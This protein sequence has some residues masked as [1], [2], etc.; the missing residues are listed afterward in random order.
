[1]ASRSSSIWARRRVPISRSRCRRDRRRHVRLWRRQ[2]ARRLRRVRAVRL[3]RRHRERAAPRD[4]QAHPK[5]ARTFHGRVAS[6]P[7]ARRT[8]GRFRH[9]NRRN[10][11]RAT[12]AA[13]ARRL[14]WPLRWC[15]A[16]HRSPSVGAFGISFGA[17]GAKSDLESVLASGEAHDGSLQACR[18]ASATSDAAP[19][20][21]TS[22][23]RVV[24]DAIG[25]NPIATDERNRHC[26][27]GTVL[28]DAGECRAPTA[29]A[30]HLCEPA[31]VADC[32]AQC[33]KGSMGSCRS[34]AA[35]MT[36]DAA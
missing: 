7:A 2:S 20:G 34:P 6:R 23:I 35:A 18:A 32:E 26:R 12:F 5:F 14:H 1:M 33:A 22:A 25:A 29:I 27:E 11:Q 31:N 36:W 21:C 30:F 8:S 15:N 9:R 19:R 3:R 24:L 4:S 10:A 17:P 28:D 13:R 16:L